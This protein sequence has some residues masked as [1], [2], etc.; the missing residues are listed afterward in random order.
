MKNMHVEE[1]YTGGGCDHLEIHFKQ[2]GLF[3]I[4]NNNDC[5]IPKDGEDWGFCVYDSEEQQNNGNYL[6]C[7]GAFDDFKRESLLDFLKGYIAA[8]HFKKIK[9]YFEL[10][11]VNYTAICDDIL[12]TCEPHVLLDALYEYVSALSKNDL[13]VYLKELDSNQSFK[14]TDYLEQ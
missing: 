4:I 13:L 10:S 9:D 7:E 8:R 5:N 3:F 14:I 2:Y 1:V 12:N 6:F 11:Q